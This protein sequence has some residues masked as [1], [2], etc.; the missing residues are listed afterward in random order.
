[1]VDLV[2]RV[3]GTEREVAQHTNI[4]EKFEKTLD[5][6]QALTEAINRI[7][8]VHEHKLEEQERDIAE[9]KTEL[10]DI[11]LKQ[12]KLRDDIIGKLET[13]E[14]AWL[15]ERLKQQSKDNSIGAQIEKW[16]WAIM[17]A[18]FVLGMVTHK[19]G[20]VAWLFKFAGDAP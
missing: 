12:D 15:E 10:H 2:S 11:N 20:F 16:K 14:K 5:S 7:A 6:L 8:A 1:M 4:I 18:I 3:T 17:G 9:L 13:L 19:M